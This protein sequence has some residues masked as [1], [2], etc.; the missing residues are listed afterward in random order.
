MQPPRLRRARDQAERLLERAVLCH[1]DV[2]LGLLASLDDSGDPLNYDQCFVR[3]FVPAALHFLI[4][5]RH[6]IVRNFLL[7][8]LKMQANERER[9]PDR[10]GAGLLPA[11]FRLEP[12]GSVDPD[13]GEEAIGRV[14]PVDSSLWWLWLLRA[15][16]R[17]TGEDLS[18][19]PPVQQ[20]LRRILGGLLQQRFELG[21]LLLVPDG[22]CMIDRRL[23]LC[24]H[25]LEI[26]VLLVGALH[27]AG[28]LLQTGDPEGRE[29]AAAVDER[30][31]RLVRHLREHYWLDRARVG[32]MRDFEHDE[33]GGDAVNEFNV[34]PDAI[35]SW[36]DR[37]IP[38][39]GG[40]LAGNV[41]PGLLDFRFFTLGNLLAVL[42][43]VL[44]QER[45][46]ALLHLLE[47]RQQDLVGA[48]PLKICYPACTGMAWR[49]TTGSDP[50]NTPW[51]YH[52]G[53][54]WP[55]L[56]WPLAA[57]AVRT[58]AEHLA[59]EALRLCAARLPQDGWPEYYDGRRGGRLG[60]AARRSQV[61]SASG[62]L[63]ALDLLEDASRVRRLF[64][65]TPVQPR[66]EPAA[67]P[68]APF[69][70]EPGFLDP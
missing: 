61:W 31:H 58:D 39:G 28:E 32:R 6:E 12:D 57:V 42:T 2:E 19:R 53:G 52:N 22:S 9:N 45:I 1:G 40:Y 59:T 3:D 23:G 18:A 64:P 8:V 44:L 63:L 55:V 21:P 50:K 14:I 35:P 47:D 37:W 60:K 66:E 15:Y 11:S 62:F 29:H 36:A 13:Y 43:G 4:R 65:D 38:E 54:H 68:G 24:G 67:R 26:Q 20:A 49:L 16:V 56:V 5:G 48:M 27:A 69:P 30:L 7:L 33:Y 34:H 10:I 25:P 70:L 41:G 46:R 51:S 17:W